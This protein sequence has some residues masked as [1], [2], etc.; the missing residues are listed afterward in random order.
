MGVTPKRSTSG[1]A[2][3]LS[4]LLVSALG[5]RSVADGEAVGW[6]EAAGATTG[7]Q[8]DGAVHVPPPPFS[9]GIF[10]CS[11]CHAYMDTNIDV[12]KLT[13]EHTKIIL[14]H[15]ER[16]GWCFECHT[17]EDRD[18]L[19]LANG[20]LI[21]FDESYKLCGQCHGPK[22]RDWKAG[23]HGKRMGEWNGTK[24]YLLC[25]HCHDPHTPRFK[26][27]E[28]KPPPDHPKE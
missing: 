2:A 13:Q 9:E 4:C 18:K 19:H 11:E 27:L 12:R 21:G 26:A 14:H 16:K 24:Q 6:R 25:A 1:T 23:V 15:G 10:P 28:P 7:E 3:L 20:D 8:V 5:C 22:L 17:N